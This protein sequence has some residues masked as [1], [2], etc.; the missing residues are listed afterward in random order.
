MKME[1]ESYNFVNG[2]HIHKAEACISLHSIIINLLHFLM[3]LL[4][5]YATLNADDG[6]MLNFG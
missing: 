4:L 3:E 5:I 1:A 6:K 2:N